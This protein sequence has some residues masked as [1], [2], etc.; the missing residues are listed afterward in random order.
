MSHDIKLRAVSANCAN[1]LPADKG[2][3]SVAIA[4]VR[5]EADIVSLW[6]SHVLA[7]FDRLLIVDHISTDGTAEFFGDL[8]TRF[9]D[10]VF[11]YKFEVPGYYQA[12]VTNALA[13]MAANAFP[14][15]WIMPLDADEFICSTKQ[16][17][18]SDL[19]AGAGTDKPVS[20]NWKTA[21]PYCVDADATL[22]T[23]TP[24]LILPNEALT[25]CKCGLHSAMIRDQKLRFIQGNHAVE[26]HSSYVQIGDLLHVPLRSLDHL[27]L[28]CT[29]GCAAYEAIAAS[30]SRS[31]QGFHWF[32]ILKLAA[33]ANNISAGNLRHI[34]AN[35][36]DINYTTLDTLS[37]YDI[38]SNGGQVGPMP[39][40]FLPHGIDMVRNKRFRGMINDIA[41]TIKDNEIR[42]LLYYQYGGRQQDMLSYS[43]SNIDALPPR[44]PAHAEERNAAAKMSDVEFIRSFTAP[45]S[46]EVEGLVPSAWIEHL[47]FMFCL[48]MQV[49]PR[50]YVE[51]GAHHG[52]SFFAACQ[53]ACRL[54]VRSECIAIDTWQGDEHIGQYG[55]T[56]FSQF[57]YIL[58]SK[59]GNVGR[60]IRNSFS[61]AAGQFAPGSIDLLHI[62]GTHTYEA[63]KNDFET[64]LPKL[65]STG[66]IIFHDT[67]VTQDGFGVYR[68]WDELS[69]KYPS[70]CFEHGH[71]LGLIY[72]GS[73]QDSPELAFVRLLMREDIGA[74][75]RQHFS[76]LGG[77]LTKFVDARN[78]SS[79]PAETEL[80][81]L[82]A[83]TGYRMLMRYYRLRDALCPENSIRHKAYVM[84]RNAIMGSLRAI[85]SLVKR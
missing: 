49:K 20:L 50:R 57:V 31:G 24:F 76:A 72:A 29:Q 66:I 33:A 71:G 25:Y 55:E 1:G 13:A 81:A 37:I 16:A 46:W 65:S 44:A 40:T 75:M 7:A 70:F 77:S 51:L 10:K 34:A 83:S 9:P 30:R 21:I 82:R 85:K 11:L 8:A 80:E 63:V 47:P 48:M 58:E 26:G 12:E 35:Y 45:S 54:D 39:V 18:F 79:S 3:R 41:D 60:Y 69:K 62:D 32:Q 14:M 38:T 2:V 23:G 64:W 15:A 17:S 59:F 53:A 56:V 6:A 22:D 84:L 28:K 4:M 67:H 73:D 74:F 61:N 78:S 36:G 43:Y 42:R 5:N 19:V 27:I 68:L 52:A